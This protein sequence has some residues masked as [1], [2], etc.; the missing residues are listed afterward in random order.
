MSSE[1]KSFESMMLRLNEIVEKLE[2]NEGNLENSIELF[3][4]GLELI[5]NCD[6][7]LKHFEDKVGELMKAYNGN[8]E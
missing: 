1:K 8:N 3:E 7:Q 2:Q 5:K 4:E 6:G